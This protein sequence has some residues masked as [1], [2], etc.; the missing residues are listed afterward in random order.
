MSRFDQDREDIIKILFSILDYARLGY[1]ISTCNNCNNCE[2]TFC[3]YRP[4]WG[5]M[6][7]WN[8]HL[9]EGEEG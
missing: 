3:E 6:V 5:E 8:C 7:R 9:W 4:R 1:E 2:K